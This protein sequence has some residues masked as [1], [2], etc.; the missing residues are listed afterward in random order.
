MFWGR[1]R[2]TMI[3]KTTAEIFAPQE[4]AKIDQRETELLT[5]GKPIFDEREMITPTQGTR[6]I[7]ARRLAIKDKKG[8]DAYILGVVDDI[9]E[10]RAAD[11]RIAQLAH[12]D[13]LTSLP[14]RT[15]F[16][17]QLER[18]IAELGPG[19]RL[20]VLYVDLDH[21]KS[22]N[23][24]LG[25]ATGDD[26]LR[27]VA[28]RLKSS[29]D[30]DDLLTRL[31][32]D[33][34]A[35]VLSDVVSLGDAYA[36]AR[37][38]RRSVIDRVLD[39]GGHKAVID[40]SVGIALAPDHG[41]A[42]SDLLKHADLALHSAK[43]DGRATC[44]HFEPEMNARM[45]L[46]R[47]L[48]MDLRRAIN[49]DQLEVHYQPVVTLQGQRVTG[50]EALVRWRHPVKGMISPVEFIPVAEDTGLITA[51]GER[52][53]WQACRDAASWP[54]DKKIAVNV[55]TVQLRNPEFPT[56]VER[57][58]KETGLDPRRLELEMT[59]SVL[60]QNTE[61]TLETLRRLQ[62]TGVGI[63]LDDFGTG[64]S[65]LSYLRRFP[66]NRIK[67]D[68]SFITDIAVRPDAQA[69]V[70]TILMLAES[71]GMTTT[72]EGVETDDQ[73]LLL[74][75]I[76]CHEMQG[77]LFSRAMPADKALRLMRDGV[78]KDTAAA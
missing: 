37:L 18:R 61:A 51:I 20:A 53:L 44:R 77:F 25:H 15:L 60:M 23:D 47:D 28:T 36:R 22:V 58:L 29:L 33:E 75:T 5:A 78:L 64:Y 49:S 56:I 13:P 35:I 34:F 73:R 16:H 24:T 50:C 43:L 66:F 63:S 68:R 55:S 71:L 14:N 45:T 21:F 40:L 48:E 31:S 42:V 57:C 38:L 74:L 9:T 30:D 32:G 62:E 72:A 26:L 8:D 27:A 2:D 41:T 39:L 12:Y 59:E 7:Y 52:V 70:R 69:I 4:A 67:I 1:S 54:D 65:S 19:Q 3:G 46:R 11:A 17:E 6:T 76:G 10:R